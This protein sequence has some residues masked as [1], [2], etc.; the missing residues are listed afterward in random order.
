ME[1][2]NEANA[3]SVVTLCSKCEIPYCV[4]ENAPWMA[5]V[6]GRQL[7][8]KAVKEN[9]EASDN[10]LNAESPPVPIFRG[11]TRSGSP[12]TPLSRSFMLLFLLIKNSKSYIL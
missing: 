2:G 10:L 6:P 11:S 9:A 8:G 5:S 12:V 4:V 7:D 1:G 3:V